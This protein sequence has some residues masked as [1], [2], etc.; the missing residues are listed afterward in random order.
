MKRIWTS[1]ALVLGMI[2]LSPTLSAEA[3]SIVPFAD[4]PVCRRHQILWV[5]TPAGMGIVDM[6]VDTRSTA[7]CSTAGGS[8]APPSFAGAGGIGGGGGLGG[9]SGGGFTGFVNSPFDLES[10]NQ[11]ELEPDDPLSF[12]GDPLPPGIGD[13]GAGGP[14]GFTGGPGLPPGS[15]FGF[16]LNDDPP[17][18]PGNS[19][20][21]LTLE[22]HSLTAVPEP[23]SFLLL[24]TGL[25]LTVRHFRRRRALLPPAI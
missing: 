14:P 19:S 10:E 12:T 1:L 18:P 16:L 17:I 6:R 25:V 7:Q 21:P 13:G 20:S 23:G 15:T 2:G 4:D 22:D 5:M 9:F 3:A 24:A 11:F 8:N